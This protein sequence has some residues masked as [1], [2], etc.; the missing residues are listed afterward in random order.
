MVNTAIS[1]WHNIFEFVVQPE[2]TNSEVV[3]VADKPA[4]KLKKRSNKTGTTKR[5]LPTDKRSSAVE[6]TCLIS[7]PIENGA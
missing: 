5:K 7:P 4:G 6:A 2:E 3:A 1:N